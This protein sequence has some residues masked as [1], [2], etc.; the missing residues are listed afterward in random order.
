LGVVKD[1]AAELDIVIPEFNIV[2]EGGVL[3]GAS[4]LFSLLAV[5]IV[6][7]KIGRV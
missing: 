2:F 7:R 4:L 3:V 1:F 6:A 5:T